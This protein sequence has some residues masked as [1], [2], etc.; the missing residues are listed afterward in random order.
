MQ[1][2]PSCH[3]AGR[4]ARRI[5]Q[6]TNA[7]EGVAYVTMR[8]ALLGKQARQRMQK[9]INLRCR[10]LCLIWFPLVR[11]LSCSHQHLVVPRDY[12][13]GPMISGFGVD[14]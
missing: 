14:G 4:L 12:E 3:C 9:I 13:E 6:R 5:G 10:W 2:V 1:E 11:N 7:G 8:E